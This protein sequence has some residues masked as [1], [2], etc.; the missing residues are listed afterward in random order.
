MQI[1]GTSEAAAITML[2]PFEHSDPA[3]L[4]TAGRPL[5]T[6]VRIRDDNDERDLPAGE[7]GEILV[8]SP[9]GMTRYVGDPELTA[10]TLRDGWLHTGD[11]GFL[12]A[13][14][15]LTISGRRSEV[16]KA[17]GI[18]IHPA[19]LERVLMTHPA[20]AQAAVFAVVDRDRLEHVHAAV[21]THPGQPEPTE[22][23]LRELLGTRLSVKHVPGRIQ[24][25]A[26]LP[27]TGIGKPDKARLAAEA[28]V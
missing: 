11:L 1:Y 16:I 9:F 6:E 3:L 4:T 19:S 7:I 21:A 27:L 12:D 22:E 24:I 10:R 28:S 14:G 2:T 8:R 18:K 25:R 5:F 17:N 15:Y 13:R 26:A 23:E 20:V